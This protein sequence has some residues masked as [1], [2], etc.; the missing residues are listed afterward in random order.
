MGGGGPGNLNAQASMS[1]AMA[2]GREHG[3]GCVALGNTNHWMRGGTYG[4]QAADAGM[5]GICWTNTLANLPAWGAKMP[6]L[7]NNPLVIAVP[8]PEGHVVLDM[9]MSQFSYGALARVP[10][11]RKAAAGG[12]RLRCGGPPDARCGSN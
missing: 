9:A 2:L 4:W 10:R 3:I 6:G 12:G 7:G 5:I 11:G 1:R 8:R